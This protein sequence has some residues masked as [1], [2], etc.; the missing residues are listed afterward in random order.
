MPEF[1]DAT[2][3]VKQVTNS[4][5]NADVW[6][7]LLTPIGVR[8]EGT[9]LA[10][11]ATMLTP[12]LSL[13]GGGTQVVDTIADLRALTTPYDEVLVLGHTSAYDGGGGRF[14]W[15]ND[16]GTV[17]DI[18]SSGHDDNGWHI[19]TTGG[20]NDVYG[21]VASVAC[22]EHF[23]GFGSVDDTAAAA[24]SDR[25]V[26]VQRWANLWANPATFPGVATHRGL[27]KWIKPRFEAH[28]RFYRCND[29]IDISTP[30]G[31]PS[32]YGG[33]IQSDLVFYGSLWRAS[34]TEFP[35]FF[36]SMPRNAGKPLVHLRFYKQLNAGKVGWDAT[37][38]PLKY[39]DPRA[40]RVWAATTEYYRNEEITHTIGGVTYLYRVTVGGTSGGTA[41]AASYST[42]TVNGSCTLY[43]LGSITTSDGRSC[44]DHFQHSRDIGVMID[45]IDCAHNIHIDG[46]NTL[47]GISAVPRVSNHSIGFA[48][49]HSRYLL[50]VKVGIL[51]GCHMWDYFVESS[52]QRKALTGVAWN[53]I[54]RQSDDATYEYRFTGAAGT[55]TSDASWTQQ[56][57]RSSTAMRWTNDDRFYTNLIYA[58][59]AGVI[60]TSSDVSTQSSYGVVSTN[61]GQIDSG[62]PKAFEVDHTSSTTVITTGS[63]AS[64]ISHGY[65]EHEEVMIRS[66]GTL[67]TG[68][69]PALRY[70]VH[71]VTS[72]TLTLSLTKGGSAVTFSSSGTG[73]LNIV[74]CGYSGPSGNWFWDM[75]LEGVDNSMSSTTY[76]TELVHFL[77]DCSNESEATCRND[78]SNKSASFIA[79]PHPST[80]ECSF[81]NVVKSLRTG[82]RIGN[83]SY[84]TDRNYGFNRIEEVPYLQE[85]VIQYTMPSLMQD[86]YFSDEDRIYFY[87]SSIWPANSSSPAEYA[88]YR[89]AA[90]AFYPKF[91]AS[92]RSFSFTYQYPL[93]Y[94]IEIP[95]NF[96]GL[97]LL[98][99]NLALGD[100]STHDSNSRCMLSIFNPN[101]GSTPFLQPTTFQSMP[102]TSGYPSSGL[103]EASSS[104]NYWLWHGSDRSMPSYF[105]FSPF[106]SKVLLRV[107]GDNLLGLTLRLHNCPNGRIYAAKRNSNGRAQPYVLAAPKRGI[108]RA[109][110]RLMYPNATPNTLELNKGAGDTE[111][112]ATSGT[113]ASLAGIEAAYQW[114]YTGTTVY[115]RDSGNTTW[116]TIATGVTPI[117]ASDWHDI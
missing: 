34:N 24:S 70:F 99:V 28:A 62:T 101:T 66:T 105:S 97:S 19:V 76:P 49:F 104:G 106:V 1:R 90:N 46:E 16:G 33:I 48:T 98:E 108:W 111:Y 7:L 88:L 73:T 52:S 5:V 80:R 54:V 64:P 68:L 56:T 21:R 75:G 3:G 44:K 71:S 10:E 8:D 103:F 81:R 15:L 58:H 117:E 89:T 78:S 59:G 72:S 35:S 41:P 85:Q 37:T 102:I 53:S 12:H 114:A 27:T 63:I 36:L 95:N 91:N 50:G 94:I 30:E 86:A 18:D 65:T 79:L 60:T 2:N 45:W 38:F 115:E 87:E 69:S 82:K 84:R 107:Y 74:S 113:V 77:M 61:F 43:G 14:E 100:P 29:T 13:S 112:W 55:E 26:A 67:P 39:R 22:P 6:V 51:I 25:S 31:S 116:N 23:G 9:T 17:G 96:Q 20:A 110:T 92:D 57:K 109:P 83:E 93:A 32:W 42:A 4:T 40:Y 47:I 11:F